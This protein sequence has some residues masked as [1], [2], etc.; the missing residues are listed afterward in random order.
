MIEHVMDDTR[1]FQ[2]EAL[3]AIDGFQHVVTS[4]PWNMATHCGP[5]TDKTLERRRRVCEWAEAPFDRLVA[6]DQIHSPHVIRVTS[7]DAGRGRDGR[8]TALRFVDGLVCDEPNLPLMQFSADCPLVLLVEPG[9]RIVGTA[10]A[11]WRGSVAGITTELVRQ[12]RV[13]FN[14]DPSRLVAAICPC[15]GPGEYEVGEEV[16]RIAIARLGADVDRFFPNVGGRL[17]FDMRGAN[18]AQLEAAGVPSDRIHVAA[19]STIAD[20]RFF[21]YRREGADTGRFAVIAGFIA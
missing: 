12:M 21:S 11:S 18:V 14:V 15:A 6:A 2:F 17:H 3:R 9:R 4:R 16:R 19:A 7:G 1:L 8:Q 10:H 5:D 13:E 20:E